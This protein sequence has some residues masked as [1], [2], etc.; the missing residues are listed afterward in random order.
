MDGRVRIVAGN[1]ALKTAGPEVL[2]GPQ[3]IQKTHL[4]LSR[5]GLGQTKC[6]LGR[7]GGLQAGAGWQF[8]RGLMNIPCERNYGA[9]ATSGGERSNALLRNDPKIKHFALEGIYTL[10]G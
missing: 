9:P 4:G 10:S 2:G 8:D 7:S 1:V 6:N 3:D 5:V